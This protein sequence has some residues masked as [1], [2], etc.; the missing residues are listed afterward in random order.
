MFSEISLCRNEAEMK[1]HPIRE[2][3]L[4]YSVSTITTQKLANNLYKCHL[5]KG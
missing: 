4:E 2:S 5:C 1:P 3:K